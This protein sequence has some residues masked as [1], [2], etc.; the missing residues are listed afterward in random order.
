MFALA[1]IGRRRANVMTTADS[2]KTYGGC[3][4]FNQNAEIDHRAR[5]SLSQYFKRGDRGGQHGIVALVHLQGAHLCGDYSANISRFRF[6][7]LGTGTNR[8][9][10]E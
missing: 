6:L 4:T 5:R 1:A 2:E 7:R 8:F 3:N 9:T 10:L